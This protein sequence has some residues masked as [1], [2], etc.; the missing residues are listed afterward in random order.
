MDCCSG[1]DNKGGNILNSNISPEK[2]GGLSTAE[3]VRRRDLEAARLAA[4]RFS[5][6]QIATQL[7]Y[8]DRSGAWRAV[9]RGQELIA[10]EPHDNMV[11][12]D[13]HE[14]D[15]MARQAWAVLQRTHY[16]VDKGAVVV[17]EG[18][19][20]ND[21]GPILAAI[22]KLLDIQRR[23]ADLVGLDAPKRLRVADALPD[24]DAA[25]QELAAELRALPGGSVSDE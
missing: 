21:D 15:E 9:R 18:R 22:A 3:A 20:L 6:D 10:R 12:L 11:L 25:V 1:C 16:V 8:D 2:R 24:L 19:P 4:L 13:L 23:R 14:L 17:W 7:G 5:Y